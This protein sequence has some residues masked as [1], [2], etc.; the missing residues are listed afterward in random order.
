MEGNKD[1]ALK[2]AQI[3]LRYIQGGDNEKGIRFLER[4]LRSAYAF[5]VRA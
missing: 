4:A 2:C 1:E 3:G 5:L